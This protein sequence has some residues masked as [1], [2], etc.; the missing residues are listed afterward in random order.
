MNIIIYSRV[1]TLGQKEHGYSLEEQVSIC[2]KKAYELGARDAEI[3]VYMDSETGQYLNRE[4]FSRLIEQIQNE[5]VNYMI[6]YDP[7]R[8]SRSLTTALVAIDII[9][10]NGVE[11]IFINSSYSKTPEGKMFFQ[12]RAVLSEYEK[13]KI[14]ARSMMGKIGKAKRKMLTHNPGLYGYNYN[15]INDILI[16]NEEEAKII[17]LM[18]KWIFEDNT[19]GMAKI[20]NRLNDMGI[21]PPRGKKVNKKEYGVSYIK[22]EGQWYKGTV[23]RILNNYS[24]TGTLFIQTVDSQ[25]VKFNKYRNEDEKIK[26]TMKP[27]EQW[28][29]IEIPEIIDI[30]IWEKLQENLKNRRNLKPGISIENYL[31]SGLISCGCCNSTLHGNRVKKKNGEGYHKYYVCTAKSP[32]INGKEKCKLP[33]INGEYLENYICGKIKEWMENPDTFKKLIINK[34]NIDELIDEKN[35]LD[36]KL[37]D[38]E[39]EKKRLNKLFIKGN[40]IEKEYD[41][42]A[43]EINNQNRYLLERFNELKNEINMKNIQLDSIDNLLNKYQN[44]KNIDDF[45][46]DD[47]KKAINTFIKKVII[48]DKYKYKIIAY[49]QFDKLDTG[50]DSL[51]CS[52]HSPTFTLNINDE[53]LK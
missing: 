47:K 13:E 11:I 49:I 9:E 37:K 33:N 38:V 52:D 53:I 24:Y 8:L 7:D 26:R 10:K 46:M 17:R 2:K 42:L 25:G 48:Y 29:A 22:E 19:L 40:I 3:T 20:A 14:K 28:I 5:D 18:I 12:I 39:F 6:L 43:Q 35:T 30:E 16:V 4:G 23:K 15:S 44:L 32:G 27:K 51:R 45:D 36:K 21:L 1:S 34:D 41:E 50:N 31:L